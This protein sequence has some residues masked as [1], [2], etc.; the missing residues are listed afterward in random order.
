MNLPHLNLDCVFVTETVVQ[1]VGFGVSL[2]ADLALSFGDIGKIYTH[3]D[4]D[5]PLYT[6][7]FSLVEYHTL[8][9]SL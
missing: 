2:S 5:T 4:F 3:F 9:F 6:P 1:L 8:Y 7:F